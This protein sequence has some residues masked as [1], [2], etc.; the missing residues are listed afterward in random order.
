MSDSTVIVVAIVGFLFL[1]FIFP[2]IMGAAFDKADKEASKGNGG[3]L[4]AILII[5]GV[6]FVIMCVSQL[7]ECENQDMDIK[8]SP[9]HTYIQKPSLNN[10][11]TLI[12]N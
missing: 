3:C 2:H 7:K 10:V 8:W 11:N 4:W 12:F 9:R 1:F 6:A 5:V